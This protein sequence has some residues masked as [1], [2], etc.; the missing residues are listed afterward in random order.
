MHPLIV[1]GIAIGIGVLIFLVGPLLT[2][3]KRK[4]DTLTKSGLSSSA[5]AAKASGNGPK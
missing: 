2:R 4:Q 1:L 5:D 3:N